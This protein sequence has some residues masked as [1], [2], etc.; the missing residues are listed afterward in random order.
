MY[1]SNRS[2]KVMGLFI[3]LCLLALLTGW[4][5]PPMAGAAAGIRV[6]PGNVDTNAEKIT[7]HGSGFSPGSQVTVGFPDVPTHKELPFAKG[8]WVSVT[9]ADKTGAFSVD[10]ELGR[11]LWRLSR[12]IGR[13]KVPG[14]YK[15][16][17]KNVEGESATAT[18]VVKQGK[19]K[20][21]KK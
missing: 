4:I 10:V 17:A 13:D 8:M 5:S 1:D 16:M 15:V 20:K 9:S 18:L 21:K 14:T 12:I 11:T 2:L 6:E 19:K 3:S 7:I